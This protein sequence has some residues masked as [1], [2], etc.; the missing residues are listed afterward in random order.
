MYLFQEASIVLENN[1]LLEELRHARRQDSRP[2]NSVDHSALEA[3]L[4]LADATIM[5]YSII[6]V[7]LCDGRSHFIL[8][9][10]AVCA[11]K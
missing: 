11:L 8:L 4:M 6:A 3:K 7:N 5:R 1:R 2:T 9:F 10:H